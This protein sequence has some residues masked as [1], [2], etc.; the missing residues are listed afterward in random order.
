VTVSAASE[1]FVDDP[2][3]TAIAEQVTAGTDSIVVPAGMVEEPPKDKPPEQREPALWMQIKAMTMAERTKLAL[4][5]N[6]DA[7]MILIRD[8]NIQIQRLVLQ[9]PR[10]TE[11]E[12]LTIAKDRNT[13]DELL[14]RIADSRDWIKNYAVRMALVEN[15]RTPV[16]KALRILPTLDDKDLSRLGK[17]KQIPQVVAGQA[18]RA[19]IH[20][21]ERR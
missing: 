14:A 6:K 18:R 7:R 8:V 17:S 13:N 3:I 12:I 9:N 19:A 16:A 21:R 2:V 10:I 4:R 15:S 11:E 20:M 1:R 5:G